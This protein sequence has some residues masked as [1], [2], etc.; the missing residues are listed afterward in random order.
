MALKQISSPPRRVKE[1]NPDDRPDVERVR[2]TN[3]MAFPR[4]AAAFL[5]LSS[6]GRVAKRGAHSTQSCDCFRIWDS[7]YDDD[8]FAF[9]Q[10][11]YL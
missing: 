10:F 3:K 6:T 11:D 2:N 9:C 5:M 4:R 7:P 1:L 8:F